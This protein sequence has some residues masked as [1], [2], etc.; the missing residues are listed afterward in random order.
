[1]EIRQSYSLVIACLMIAAVLLSIHLETN[2]RLP[3]AMNSDTSMQ[4]VL[5]PETLTQDSPE[6]SLS[7]PAPNETTLDTDAVST[8][9]EPTDTDLLT[10][11]ITKADWQNA[12]A[13]FQQ[14]GEPLLFAGQIYLYAAERYA[15]G[16][17]N[18]RY[19]DINSFTPEAYWAVAQLYQQEKTELIE[20][21]Y[22]WGA[23]DGAKETQVLAALHE[24][25]NST[26]GFNA[27]EIYCRQ[28]KCTFQYDAEGDGAGFNLKAIWSIATGTLAS[29]THSDCGGHTRSGG[30]GSVFI[31]LYCQP[32]EKK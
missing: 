29:G 18:M 31:S 14:T 9:P 26:A 8:Q 20:K 7:A 16:Q 19:V 27:S 2:E 1:M 6:T 28:Y 22:Q 23:P 3:R 25:E 5:A 13:Q 4:S 17:P 15:N 10:W 32:A 24:L 21:G 12:I 11:G 30:N